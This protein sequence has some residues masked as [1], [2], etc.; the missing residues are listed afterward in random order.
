MKFGHPIGGPKPL[1]YTHN[2]KVLGPRISGHEIQK[3]AGAL[4]G[5]LSG[6]LSGALSGAL[7]SGLLSGTLS[8]KKSCNIGYN[9][10]DHWWLLMIQ[11]VV[12]IA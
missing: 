1:K 11:L 6:T 8:G 10:N 9:I 4:S 7:F 3:L 12:T 5:T 2:I